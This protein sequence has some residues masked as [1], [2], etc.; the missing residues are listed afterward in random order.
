MA[1]LELQESNVISPSG[2]LMHE[3]NLPKSRQESSELLYTIGPIP[4]EDY[5]PS[6]EGKSFQNILK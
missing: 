6:L 3:I 4:T 2:K 1:L 5:Q